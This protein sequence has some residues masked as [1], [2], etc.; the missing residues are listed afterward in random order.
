M[1][2]SVLLAGGAALIVGGVVM[3]RSPALPWEIPGSLPVVRRRQAR[4]LIDDIKNAGVDLDDRY[5]RFMVKKVDPLFGGTRSAALA[6]IVSAEETLEISE[7]ERQLNRYLAAAGA[8]LATSIFGAFYPP[9]LIVT[10][11]TAIYST[12]LIF[13]NGYEAIVVE[14]RLRMDVMGSLYFIGAYAGGFF[15]AG[16]FGLFAFYLSEKLVMITQDRSQKSLINVF[17]QQPR[18]VWILVDG[19]EVEVPFESLQANDIVSLHTGQVIP[20]DGLIEEGN[21]TI[22]QHM[23]TGEAQ[24][25]ERGVGDRVLTSTMLVGGKIYVRVE[26]TGEA[27]V[28]AQIG[29]MLNSTASFQANIVSKGEQIADASVPPSLLA[30]LIGLYLTGYQAMVTIF[31]SAIGLNIKI[32]AP[33]AMLNFLNVAAHNG[34]LVKDGRSLEL[35]KDVDTVIFDK[36][37]TL[38]LEQPN[39][40]RIHICN[41]Y[42][43]TEVLT[44]AAAAEYRQTHP[45]ARAILEEAARQKLS[46]PAIDHAHYDVG[47]GLR[48]RL[49]GK[50]IHVGSDRYMTMETIEIPVEIQRLKE[51]AQAEAHSLVMVGVNDKLA[52]AIEL[53]PTIRPEAAEIVQNLLKRG[54]D[55]W[56]IS[57]DQEEPTRKL[58]HTLGIPHYFANTLPENKA[59]M[60][61]KLQSEGRSVCFVGDGINDSIALKKANVSV[62]LRGASTAAT[63]TAQVV[64][65]AQSLRQLPYL[66]DLAQEFDTNMKAGFAAAVGQGVV[67]ISGALL[68][69]VGILGGTLIWEVGLLAGLGVAMLPLRRVRQREA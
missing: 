63:D 52:G 28:A 13:R 35:L 62:S 17:S 4:S 37:G 27:T 29:K 48:V 36:T 68:G 50:L 65:M 38:T 7:Y 56:V 26:Q 14:R 31:G 45:V 10:L 43:A 53:Q 16:S 18:T 42:S 32:T 69:W 58:T 5:Q 1:L 11:V 12:T 25:V 22:D 46:L 54:I 49:D 3:Q 60:V 2:M 55:I 40:A 15:M 8:T 64:L 23:L 44:F 61:E 20:I 24:P 66:F 51:S 19:S 6:E 30:G 39:V 67:V 9:V 21:A 47:Y 33:I 59:A 34:I 41:G 57:G